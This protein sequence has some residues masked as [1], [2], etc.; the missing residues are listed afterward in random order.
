M[1]IQPTTN[2][3]SI[4]WSSL[5][6]KLA[7]ASKAI[8]DLSKQMG[9]ENMEAAKR[10]HDINDMIFYILHHPAETGPVQILRRII[11]QIRIIHKLNVTAINHVG[12][13]L[14]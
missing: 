5:L 13:G 12:L 14:A 9:E 8:D 6:N 4:D 2:N 10:A 11:A 7:A 3:A 1:S